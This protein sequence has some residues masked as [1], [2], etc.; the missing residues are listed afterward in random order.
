MRSYHQ[1]ALLYHYS[2]LGS[3][4]TTWSLRTYISLREITRAVLV[5]SIFMGHFSSVFFVFQVTPGLTH[6]F[7]DG[8]PRPWPTTHHLC[9][10]L[11]WSLDQGK[12]VKWTGIYILLW[13]L[14]LL[15]LHLS[16]C[17]VFMHV[18]MHI[19]TH[20]GIM[21]V[22]V[23]VCLYMV[24]WGWHWGYSLIALPLIYCNSFFKKNWNWRLSR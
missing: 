23:L 12:P 13:L 11:F 2:L 1:H 14:F 19:Y 7:W 5:V 22:Y 6:Y 20:V 16:L 9:K 4:L 24:A 17:V 10:H 3:C 18:C 8:F 15:Y 21:C